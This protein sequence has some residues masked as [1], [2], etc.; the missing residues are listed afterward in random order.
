MIVVYQEKANAIEKS[1]AARLGVELVA[2]STLGETSAN[3]FLKFFPEGLSLC[4]RETKAAGPTRVDFFDTALNKRVSDSVRNQNLIKALGLKKKPN[5]KVLDA[6]AGLGKD[7]YLMASVGCSVQMLEKSRVV[8]ELLQDGLDRLREGL[9]EERVKG[10]N[11][12]HLDFLECD[13]A[14]GEY[15]VVYLDPMYPLEKRKSRA[16]K[17]MDRLHA[18]LGFEK[19]DEAIFNKA[20][21]IAGRRVVVKRPKKAANFASIEPDLFYQGSSARFDIYLS[22]KRLTSSDTDLG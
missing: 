10:L 5:P 4:E 16:K 19:L 1:L 7:A 15:D 2:E 14:H 9:A 13:Y 11:L 6:M 21:G 12:L 22:K 3:L 18:L 17:D 8:Y 20:M